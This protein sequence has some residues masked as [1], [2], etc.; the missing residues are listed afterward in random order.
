MVKLTI[1]DQKVTVPEGATIMQAARKVG[2]EIPHL[3]YLRDIDVY[4]R[5]LQRH[6]GCHRAG[7][8]GDCH[9]ILVPGQLFRY[10]ERNLYRFIISAE[11]VFSRYFRRS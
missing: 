7:G 4:K 6:D 1:N 8:F 9:E 11:H 2:I 3:C 5:Q 10:V